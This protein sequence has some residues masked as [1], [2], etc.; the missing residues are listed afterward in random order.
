MSTL[1]V[2]NLQ[3]IYPDNRVTV[4][5]GHKLYAPGHV[6]QVVQY[7]FT[8]QVSTTSTSFVDATGFAASITPSSTSSK[9]L[10]NLSSSPYASAACQMEYR[11]LRNGIDPA[12]ITS[13][14]MWSGCYSPASG[15]TY[16]HDVKFLDS[17]GTT[18]VITYQVQ[19]RQRATAT[20]TIG[21][22]WN[23][24]QAGL[25]TLVLMEIAA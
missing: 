16:A 10:V 20:M 9:V 12:S 6:L 3:G 2:K 17:P 22:D 24:D 5:S 15:V 21:K 4:P 23:G 19:F 14:R 8:G 13:G 18:A 7:Q 11:I 1:N 25:H